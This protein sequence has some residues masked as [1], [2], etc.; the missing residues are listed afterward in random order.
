MNNRPYRRPLRIQYS[1]SC[2]SSQWFPLS[3]PGASTS[4]KTQENL[5]A[6]LEI[7][8]ESLSCN[9]TEMTSSSPFTCIFLTINLHVIDG[10]RYEKSFSFIHQYIALSSVR[11]SQQPIQE[12]VTDLVLCILGKFLVFTTIV[13]TCLC[14]CKVAREP[15]GKKWNYLS[16][17]CHV[18]PQKWPLPRHLFP[19]FLPQIQK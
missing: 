4:A 15:S 12:T 9:F 5:A 11:H 14:L 10:N 3:S 7:F 6:K 17:V 8:F 2:A 16:K 18:I 1:G 19:Y 13:A